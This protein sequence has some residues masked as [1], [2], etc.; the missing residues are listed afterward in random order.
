MSDD[1]QGQ[2]LTQIGDEDTR[3]ALANLMQRSNDDW[4]KNAIACSGSCGQR[5]SKV[6]YLDGEPYC[7]SCYDALFESQL[8][9]EQATMLMPQRELLTLEWMHRAGLSKRELEA[10]L[11][12]NTEAIK[13][14]QAA[15]GTYWHDVVGGAIPDRG[16]G[17][18]GIAGIGKSFALAAILK[19]C[20]F[21][22]LKVQLERY[23]AKGT[24]ALWLSWLRWPE[25]VQRIRT[26]SL[27]DGGHEEIAEWVEG[28]SKVP[29]LVLDDLGAERIR[30]SYEEDF[31]TSMLDQVI[32][33]RCGAML[34]TWF[35]TNLNFDA[36]RG[37]I[38]AR[39]F[40]R[41]SQ[42]A[43]LVELPEGPDLRRG[44]VQGKR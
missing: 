15:L 37:R 16:L 29:L 5:Y 38:G 18:A 42:D 34:P 23:G 32:D 3:A 39:M 2:D 9:R 6:L 35:T 11:S 44:K 36:L 30:G 27:R 8:N 14:V 24:E 10:G 20:V 41:L 19:T 17:V 22:W 33:A 12:H 4:E 43:T 28:W 31:A 1:A 7:R 25:T 40:S 26:T 13:R 21:R